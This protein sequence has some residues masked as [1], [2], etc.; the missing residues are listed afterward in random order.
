LAYGQYFPEPIIS[1]FWWQVKYHIA[2]Y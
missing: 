2:K 1:S